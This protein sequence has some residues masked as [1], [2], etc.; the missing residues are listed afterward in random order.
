MYTRF[1]KKGFDCIVSFFGIVLLLPLF[2]LLIVILSIA[3]KGNPFFFQKRMGL[4]GRIF[5]I[6]KFKTMNDKRDANGKFLSDAIRLTKVGSCIRKYS[7]DEIPQLF[8]VLFG[9]MSIVGPRP[10]L[11]TY[12]NLYTP[13]QNRRHEVMPGITGWA[14]V[15][16]RNAIDWETKFDYDVYYVDTISFKLDIQILYKTIKRIVTSKDINFQNPQAIEPFSGQPTLYI[17]G[18][19]KATKKVK[20]LVA[21]EAKFTVVATIFL[22]KNENITTA[23]QQVLIGNNCI[24]AIKNNAARQK[25]AALLTTNFVVHIHPKARVSKFTKLGMGTQ[26]QSDALI[27]AYSKIGNHCR[28][29]ADVVLFYYCEIAD[30]VSIASNVSIA[31]NVSIGK[32]TQIK[33]GVA[34]AA[35]VS[36]GQNV[37]IGK[38]A[39]I[40]KNIPDN[41]IIEANSIY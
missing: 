16:G 40:T 41:T 3:N 31:E 39:K 21:A 2:L 32:L 36:I 30:F 20:D 4:E 25:A 15:N 14:Q 23:I 7:L 27:K 6:F 34:V 19:R 24:I 5:S 9:Q 33:K 37:Y 12:M 8:N 18:K 22:S 28:I 26:I 35:N 13:Y 10:L 29:G 38:Q 17:V 1:V 11:T